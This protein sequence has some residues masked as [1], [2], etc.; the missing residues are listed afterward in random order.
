MTSADERSN[1]GDTQGNRADDGNMDDSLE[2]AARD[3]REYARE[4]L[5]EQLGRE[6]SDDE[7]NE[8]L[9]EQT[10]GY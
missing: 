6:P 8:W 5:N 7:I 4:R 1:N 10:E 2:G 3:E 9:R